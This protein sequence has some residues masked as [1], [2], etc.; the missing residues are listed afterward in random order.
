MCLTMCLLVISWSFI[1]IVHNHFLQLYCKKLN[2]NALSHIHLWLGDGYWL[3]LKILLIQLPQTTQLSCLLPYW[4]LINFGCMENPVLTN[5]LRSLKVHESDGLDKGSNSGCKNTDF[6]LYRRIR[7]NHPQV[8]LICDF[9]K[10]SKNT[11]HFVN[12]VPHQ[13]SERG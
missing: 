10:Y 9:S 11:F 4:V 3:R 8:S 12:Y 5:E 6:Q 1:N 2:T 7:E 13:C